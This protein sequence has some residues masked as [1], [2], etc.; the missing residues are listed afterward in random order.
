MIRQ[1]LRTTS[2]KVSELALKNI[3]VQIAKEELDLSG[4]K[5]I[6]FI[7]FSARFLKWYGVQNSKRSHEDYDNLFNSTIIPHFKDYYLSDINTEM[8]EDYKIQ[9]SQA[10]KPA[11]VNKELTA[12]K[13]LFNKAI[14]WGYIK[15]NPVACDERLPMTEKKIKFLSLKEIDLVLERSP[16]YLRP[17]IYYCCF[18]S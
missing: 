14:R 13:H 18:D 15:K 1:S 17:R 12:L 3:E 6:M 2:K 7:D 9:R 10:I 4:I 8:I 11:T 5:K 16:A